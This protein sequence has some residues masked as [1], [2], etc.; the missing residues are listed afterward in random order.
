MTTD[1]RD[2][3]SDRAMCEAATKGPWTSEEKFVAQG[4]APGLL[5]VSDEDLQIIA[6][7]GEIGEQQNH[8]NA[9]FIAKAR[10]A[11][12]YYIDRCEA[13]EA[14][15]REVTAERDSLRAELA[16]R[17]A[18][19]AA[20]RWALEELSDDANSDDN[21]CEAT[22]D[23]IGREDE[24][25]YS[26]EHCRTKWRNLVIRH[27][28]SPSAGRDLLERLQRDKIDLTAE[29]DHCRRLYGVALDEL[30]KPRMPCPPDKRCPYETGKK[31]T[32]YRCAQCWMEY[33]EQAVED[34][35]EAEKRG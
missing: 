29:R 20:M 3:A 32:E 19:C 31:A 4:E 30:S 18:E 21:Y 25:E 12:P 24:C 6:V 1:K 17:D 16:E 8:P 14:K 13:A 9:V 11:L 15:V 10:E 35:E 23:C 34:A 22:C 28:L 26:E 7:V 33:V 2:I 27:A 5:A